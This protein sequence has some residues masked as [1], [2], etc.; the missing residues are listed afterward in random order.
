ML[1]TK[2]KV[3]DGVAHQMIVL[4]PECPKLAL[5]FIDL[6]NRLKKNGDI[7][8]EQHNRFFETMLFLQTYRVMGHLAAYDEKPGEGI[9]VRL[10]SETA[11]LLE[12]E[13][14]GK[15]K[16]G[17]SF[18]DEVAL[19]RWHNMTAEERGRS[20]MDLRTGPDVQ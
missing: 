8:T 3:I 17:D 10:H 2:T 7:T 11:D 14:I 16:P 12:G 5:Q 20:A 18:T 1:R 19:R 13:V 4:R 6:I 9:I 15:V